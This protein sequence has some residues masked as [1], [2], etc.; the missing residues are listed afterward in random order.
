[1]KRIYFWVLGSILYISIG[2]LLDTSS[3]WPGCQKILKLN[4]CCTA[5]LCGPVWWGYWVMLHVYIYR[6]YP[7]TYQPLYI[8]PNNNIYIYKLN[9]G[10]GHVIL[11]LGAPYYCFSI[12]NTDDYKYIVYM[13]VFVYMCNFQETP[14]CIF[15]IYNISM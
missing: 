6:Y 9:L 11:C 4:S 2:W 5:G 15:N 3:S 12:P 8:Q 13:H 7:C 1:M 10:T 14:I